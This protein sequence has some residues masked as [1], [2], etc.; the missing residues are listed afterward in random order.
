MAKCERGLVTAKSP[1]QEC[2]RGVVTTG[3]ATGNRWLTT[4]KQLQALPR[5]PLAA[6]RP[7]TQ[8]WVSE[9]V[10][11]VAKLTRAAS[12]SQ[13]IIRELYSSMLAWRADTLGK[14]SFG[15][16]RARSGDRK[17]TQARVRA[18]SGDNRNCN[19]QLVAYNWQ[20]TSG[21]TAYSTGSAT[22]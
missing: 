8:L 12:L 18:Q 11:S 5:T 9:L 2:E 10:A 3:T 6:L 17:I 14:V 7:E 16:V 4:G 22:T 20:A 19:W 1:K 13:A 21:T 15:K